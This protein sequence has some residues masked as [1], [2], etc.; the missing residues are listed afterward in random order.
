MLRAAGDPDLLVRRGAPVSGTEVMVTRHRDALEGQRLTVLGRSRR[1]GRAELL[2]VLPDGSKRVIPE[3]W[4]DQ[5]S[6]SGRAAVLASPGDL[7][8]L[9][10]LVP[11]LSARCDGDREQAARQSPCKEDSDCSLCR[12]ICCRTRFR[13]HPRP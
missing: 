9:R 13:R 2:V 11:P 12:S 6:G 5:A 10:L 7:L 1:S 4:T 8:A 3:A